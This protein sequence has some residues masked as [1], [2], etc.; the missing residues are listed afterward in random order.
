MDAK[1][2]LISPLR[3]LVPEQRVE[4]SPKLSVYCCSC[5]MFIILLPSTFSVDVRVHVFW[6]LI[7]LVKDTSGVGASPHTAHGQSG[8][9]LVELFP[10][11]EN[12]TDKQ[13]DQKHYSTNKYNTINRQ[14]VHVYILT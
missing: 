9:Q 13:C 11:Q 10:E 1:P 12:V 2:S 14:R 7:H 6:L 8:Q 4:C 5:S 3:V